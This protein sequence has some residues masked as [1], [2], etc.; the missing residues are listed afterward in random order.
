MPSKHIIELSEYA[1]L[2]RSISSVFS[3]FD[4]RRRSAPGSFFT[5]S[6]TSLINAF[7]NSNSSTLRRSVSVS[8]LSSPASRLRHGADAVL[9]FC[10]AF[11]FLAC[12]AAMPPS[13]YALTQLWT[14]PM[15]TPSRRAVCF[16]CMPPST[17]SIA[18]VLVSKGMMGFAIWP[19]YLGSFASQRSRHCLVGYP[20]YSTTWAVVISVVKYK[21]TA[22]CR[23]SGLNIR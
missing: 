12:N 14:A 18:F 5:A 16:C 19:A 8:S 17:S 11:L 6:T 13:R 4:R 2:R 15:L 9:P 22:R 10:A 23:S 3:L 7:S 20:R 1:G 21:S